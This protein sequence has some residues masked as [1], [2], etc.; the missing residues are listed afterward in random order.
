[1]AGDTPASRP[2]THAG[3]TRL[4]SQGRRRYVD[5]IVG[6]A[7]V[8]CPGREFTEEERVDEDR[9]GVSGDGVA[10]DEMQ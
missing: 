5:D 8:E 2:P 1:M 3:P 9:V 10:S 4:R 7:T 6:D